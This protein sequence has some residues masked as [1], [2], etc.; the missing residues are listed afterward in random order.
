MK[1]TLNIILVVC[2]LFSFTACNTNQSSADAAKQAEVQKQVADLKEQVS[3]LKDEQ[4]GVV[5]QPV[6]P[7]VPAKAGD[8]AAKTDDKTVKVDDTSITIDTPKDQA[9]VSGDVVNFSGTLSAGVTKIVATSSADA[10]P[11]TLQ[12]FKAGSTKF[13]YRASLD[14]KNLKVGQNTFEFTA[15]FKDG[16]TKTAKVTIN[17]SK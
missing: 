13:S 5:H 3:K 12:S 2:A 6:V 15:Y 16:S 9:D 1:K 11:Y 7:A 8:V 17:F 10:D 14:F 4:D